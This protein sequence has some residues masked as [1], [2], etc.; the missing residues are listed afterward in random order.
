MKRR[1][2]AK[3]N[4]FTYW[5]DGEVVI[6]PPGKP[7]LLECCNC[8]L[9]HKITAKVDGKNVVLDCERVD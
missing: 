2:R 9:V 4:G 1:K 7:L 3:R 5:R 6:L 8:S